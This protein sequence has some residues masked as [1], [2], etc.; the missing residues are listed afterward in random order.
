M[1]PST[2][3]QAD[4]NDFLVRLQD[5]EVIA[6]L[7][8]AGSRP[9]QYGARFGLPQADLSRTTSWLASQNLTVDSV[10]RGRSTIAFSGAVRDVENAF[11][12]EIHR[13]NVDGE[14]HFANASEPSVPSA[15]SSVIRAIHGLDDFRLKPHFRPSRA[16]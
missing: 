1:E 3:Q 12:I 14:S 5:P 15:L 4:L 7:S 6:R 8:I 13:Y 11:G 2:A 16:G 9:E 10:G